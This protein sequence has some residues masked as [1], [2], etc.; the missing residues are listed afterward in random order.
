MALDWPALVL[1]QP[2]PSSMRFPH[3][4]ACAPAGMEVDL[5]G[6]RPCGGGVWQDGRLR[7]QSRVD[8]T[9]SRLEGFGRGLASN[10]EVVEATGKS[11]PR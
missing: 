11:I 9:R 3:P 10:E 5:R 1:L 7:W 8:M 4:L 2:N 6:R